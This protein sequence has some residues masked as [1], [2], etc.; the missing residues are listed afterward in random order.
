MMRHSRR[1]A[2][3][4]SVAAVIAA[5]A[6]ATAL[7]DD[8]SGSESLLCYG[9]EAA[10]CETGAAC[11]VLQPWQLNMPDFVKLDLRGKRMHTT[12]TSAE[13]RDTE[14]ESIE[15]H[16]GSILLQGQQDERAFSWL[17]TEATGEGTLSIAASGLGLT[18]FT[19]CTP[20]EKL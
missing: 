10:R 3:S 7:A 5:F 19:T 8:V 20:V 18:V 12:A 9:L 14:I 11:E 2:S 13:Q 6:G 17:I 4:R 15:R 16:N 1:V